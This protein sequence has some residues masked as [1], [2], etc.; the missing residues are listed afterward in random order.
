MR[1]ERNIFYSRKYYIQNIKSECKFQTAMMKIIICNVFIGLCM[2]RYVIYKITV[3]NY[4]VFVMYFII[5]KL[6]LTQT[7]ETNPVGK[8][9][10]PVFSSPT[11]FCKKNQSSF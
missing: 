10:N 6:N 5:L 8:Q 3:I 1:L 11:G 2:K 7:R 4:S 9:S